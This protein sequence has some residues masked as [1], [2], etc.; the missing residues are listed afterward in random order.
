MDE[1]DELYTHDDF[2]EA[3]VVHAADGVG[4]CAV[5]LLCNCP[6]TKLMFLYTRRR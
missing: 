2:A 1:I 4:Q 3:T 5:C 6:H